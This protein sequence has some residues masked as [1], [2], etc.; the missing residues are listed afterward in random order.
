MTS[1]PV[2]CIESVSGPWFCQTLRDLDRGV[3]AEATHRI[4]RLGTRQNMQDL[5]ARSNHVGLLSTD[6]PFGGYLR[7]DCVDAQGRWAWTNLIAI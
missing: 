3:I 4:E 7:V 1:W 2:R 6:Q 5:L